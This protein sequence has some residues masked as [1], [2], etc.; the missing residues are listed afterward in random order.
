M[1]ETNEK[2]EKML[3]AIVQSQDVDLLEKAFR[4]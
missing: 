3:I 1:N 4:S 2:N